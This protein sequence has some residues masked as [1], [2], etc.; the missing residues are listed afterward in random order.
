MTETETVAKRKRPSITIELQDGAPQTR[1]LRAIWHGST[2]TN[3]FGPWVVW[4]R[5][6]VGHDSESNALRWLLYEMSRSPDGPLALR[7]LIVVAERP[8]RRFD[9]ASPMREAYPV[10]KIHC[11]EE[12]RC[13]KDAYSEDDCDCYCSRCGPWNDW[14]EKWEAKEAAQARLAERRKLVVTDRHYEDAYAAGLEAGRRA[15]L[16]LPPVESPPQPPVPEHER[17]MDDAELAQL[18]ATFDVEVEDP[19]WGY[20][21]LTVQRLMATLDTVKRELADVE[22]CLTDERG[23]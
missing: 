8:H 16:G 9:E 20:R 6:E 23:S 12:E 22:L 19:L 7:D 2:F 3:F 15:A 18:R 13:N 5:S 1:R 21:K 10:G 11:G 4:F 14:R 17:P